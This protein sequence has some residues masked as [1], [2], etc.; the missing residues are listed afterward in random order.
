[1][2][3]LLNIDEITE[4]SPAVPE[5]S[6]K[7]RLINKTDHIILEVLLLL[8]LLQRLRS[9]DVQQTVDEDPG[10]LELNTRDT[11]NL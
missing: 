3:L 7:V 11:L 10:G 9:L 1:M 6:A 8:L 5:I 4:F 2:I